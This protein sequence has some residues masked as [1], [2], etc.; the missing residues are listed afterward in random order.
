[1]EKTKGWPELTKQVQQKSAK[2]IAGFAKSHPY[3]YM[4]KCLEQYPYWGNEDNGFN[5]QKNLRRF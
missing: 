4:R 1:M 5:R 2:E 3:E